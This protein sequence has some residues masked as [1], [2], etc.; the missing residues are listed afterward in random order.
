MTLN[1]CAQKKFHNVWGITTLQINPI[2]FETHLQEREER[3][4]TRIITIGSQNI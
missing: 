1:N 3:N 2:G 4:I